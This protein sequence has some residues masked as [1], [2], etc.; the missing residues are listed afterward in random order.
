LF[1]SQL[2]DLQLMDEISEVL[3]YRDYGGENNLI[4]SLISST[5][6]DENI[7]LKVFGSIGAT[8][9]IFCWGWKLNVGWDS[10]SL[11]EFRPN[12]NGLL[13]VFLVWSSF[14]KNKK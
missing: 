12:A 14:S 7:N 5:K 8:E 9:E 1:V 13:E 6:K 11:T 2:Y 10:G 4:T 3:L